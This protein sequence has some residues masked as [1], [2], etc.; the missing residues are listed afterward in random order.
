MRKLLMVT[1][2]AAAFC[3]A[4]TAQAQYAGQY[5]YGQYGGGYSGNSDWNQGRRG[6]S[7]F[8]REYR[9][10]I[11]GIRHGLSDG[12]FSPAQANRFYRELQSIRYDAMRS[13][14]YGN[15]QDTYIQ[16]RMARLHQIMHFQHDRNHERY[17]GYGNY[18][19]YGDYAP[20]NGGYDYGSGHNHEHDDD[21]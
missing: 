14:R 4:G 20:N 18:G 1:A 21:D 7:Q 16:A 17:D 8:D 9:H 19:N 5:G 12:T 10:T 3:A 6:Y 2:V 11:E 13:M 15:Y